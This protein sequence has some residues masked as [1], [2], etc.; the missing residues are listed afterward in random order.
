[1]NKRERI[2][3]RDSESYTD[4]CGIGSP[5]TV[6]GDGSWGKPPTLGLI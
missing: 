3:V 2:R 1:M 4:P 5:A 6:A